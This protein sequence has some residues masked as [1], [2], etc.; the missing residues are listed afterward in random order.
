M[1]KSFLLIGAVLLS[2]LVA[3]ATEESGK[4]E[5]FAGYSFVRFNPNSGCSASVCGSNFLPSFNA[6]GGDGQFVYNFDKGLG[7]A[8]DLGAVTKGELN[9]V[10]VDTTVLN[11]VLGPRYT[12]HR[13]DSRFQPFVQALFGGAYA[14]SST[15]LDILGGTIVNPFIFPPITT[16]PN[17][18]I[19]ARLVESRTG[20]AMLAG[21]GLDIKVSKHMSIRPVGADYYLTRLPDFLTQ[22]LPGHNHRNA[23]NFRYTAGVN[24]SFGKE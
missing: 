2:A 8:F 24:F 19:T 15:H 6:N 12:Y 18:P 16:N 3:S 1:R 9:H 23:N 4:Y 7:V 20:F 5:T 10:A 14:T 17:S 22:N 11:F 21:G 13:H